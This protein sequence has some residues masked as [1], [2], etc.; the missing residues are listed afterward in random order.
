MKKL[1]ADFFFLGG[2]SFLGSF[3]LTLVDTLL[4][5]DF[6]VVPQNSV[7]IY[8]VGTKN[9]FRDICI[10]DSANSLSFDKNSAEIPLNFWKLC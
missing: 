6:I 10:Q 5:T 3:P 4:I 9:I 1:F 7:E 2:S 8:G